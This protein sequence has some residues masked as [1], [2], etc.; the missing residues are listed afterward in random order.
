MY[1]ASDGRIFESEE[2]ARRA[3]A[4]GCGRRIPVVRT[5]VSTFRKIVYWVLSLSFASCLAYGIYHALLPE[6]NAYLADS[7]NDYRFD[8]YG[9]LLVN[10]DVVCLLEAWAGA[11]FYNLIGGKERNHSFVALILSLFFG[12]FGGIGLGNILLQ[13]ICWIGDLL[14]G[15]GWNVIIW[16]VV[17][18]IVWKGL[19]D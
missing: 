14:F 8:L 18:Y 12:A 1:I 16:M 2:A 3:G 19:F 11:S 15:S 17:I 9:F 4:T 7:P 10:A 6:I 13:F 5:R